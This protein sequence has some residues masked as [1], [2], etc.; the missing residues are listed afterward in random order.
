VRIAKRLQCQ[1]AIGKF[2]C[3]FALCK[4]F[5][6]ILTDA[7]YKTHIFPS[8]AKCTNALKGEVDETFIEIE[9]AQGC[10]V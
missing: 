3:D 10:D 5:H 7:V 8:A 9:V 1:K 4:Y 6:K 2:W